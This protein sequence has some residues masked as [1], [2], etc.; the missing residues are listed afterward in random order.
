M[1]YG[2]MN[3]R[4]LSWKF[5][6]KRNEANT[7]QWIAKFKF[8]QALQDGNLYRET[9]RFNSMAVFLKKVFM[10]ASVFSSLSFVFWQIIPDG[11]IYC[12]PLFYSCR[13]FQQQIHLVLLRTCYPQFLLLLVLWENMM[14]RNVLNL[15]RRNIKIV[16]I[17][18]YSPSAEPD[19]SRDCILLQCFPSTFL[20]VRNTIYLLHKLQGFK[21]RFTRRIE[22]ELEKFIVATSN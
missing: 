20:P 18:N 7:S 5:N 1:F 19:S 21:R 9:R 22:N 10:K 15:R 3:D 2:T 16:V 13:I 11:P 17:V 8:F 14:S 6:L 4:C 12:V